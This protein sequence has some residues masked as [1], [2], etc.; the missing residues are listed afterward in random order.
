[1]SKNT[2]FATSEIGNEIVNKLIIM[3]HTNIGD[4]M[5]VSETLHHDPFRGHN[6]E[7]ASSGKSTFSGILNLMPT[8]VLHVIQTKPD[9]NTIIY[10]VECDDIIGVERGTLVWENSDLTV[11]ECHGCLQLKGTSQNVRAVEKAVKTFT[12]I[13]TK[14]KI[15]EDEKWALATAFP[16]I[17]GP[18]TGKYLSEKGY[19]AGDHVNESMIPSEHLFHV[20]V[21]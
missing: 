20:I 9:T 4:A 12:I 3:G 13:L 14:E 18:N 5:R 2:A 10:T 7:D 15:G 6:P 16:G 8:K 11:V 1:M 21:G 19:K 17:P